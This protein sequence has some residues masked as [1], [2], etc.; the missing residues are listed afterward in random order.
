MTK[1]FTT[2]HGEVTVQ[3][4]MIDTN[5]TDLV[6]GVEIKLD[7][8]LIGELTDTTFSYVEDYEVEEIEAIVERF[9]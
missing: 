1:T 9:I 8:E 4:A 6:D 3:G 5:G 7:G 2:K